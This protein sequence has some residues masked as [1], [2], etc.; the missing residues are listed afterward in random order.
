MGGYQPWRPIY[1]SFG[2]P[3]STN[4]FNLS[5]DAPGIFYALRRMADAYPDPVTGKNTAISAAFAIEAVP[6]FVL[7]PAPA[8]TADSGA[9]GTAN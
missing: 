5:I 1:V 2:L 7:D 3:G 4:E 6:A 8:K 9:V